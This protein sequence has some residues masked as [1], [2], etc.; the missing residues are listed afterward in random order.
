MT[1]EGHLPLSPPPST[2]GRHS[3]TV[4]ETRMYYI[5]DNTYTLSV[6]LPYAGTFDF[7]ISTYGTLSAT[8]CTDRFPRSGSSNKGSFTVQRDN[9]VVRF[10]YKFIDNVVTVEVAD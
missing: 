5:G 10:R 3:L 4:S 6:V 8:Y 7:A 2:K 9:S 1:S